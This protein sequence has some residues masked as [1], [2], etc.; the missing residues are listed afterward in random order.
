MC[1]RTVCG[2]ETNPQLP[3]VELSLSDIQNIFKPEFIRQLNRMFICGNYGDPIAAKD[4]LE[5]YKY[6]RQENP[7]IRLD[8]FTNGSAR[9]E[10]WW[11]ELAKVIDCIHF[12][13]DG[14]EDTNHLYRRGTHFPTIMKSI[15][16]Y[17]GN[18]G[19]AVWDFIVFRHNEHQIEEVKKLSEELGF[20]KLNIKKTGRFFSNTRMQVKDKQ[21]VFT[22]SG[23]VDYYIEMPLN[24]KYQNQALAKE[25]ALV[26]KYGSLE[27]YLDKT[28]IRC[29]VDEEK[30]MYLSAVG[31]AFPCCWTG[32]QLY[33]WYF[34]EKKSYMWK[35][36]NEL[37]NGIDDL[38]TKVHSLES[39]VN[40]PFFQKIMEN[41]W[42]RQSI[43]EGRPKCCAKTC[44][45][46]FDPFREQFI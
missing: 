30:S 41:S 33:P 23:E 43:K 11:Q 12:S 24:E 36:V 19:K 42:E 10:T 9:P 1:L 21:V 28:P 38:D 14:L 15:K 46:E 34:P 22:K 2:G 37:E 45:T 31:H 35:L 7:N 40:G 27:K 3:L 8:M 18:G 13:I 26:E 4:T 17:I 5:V 44:G 29:K 6:F 32:N 16:A 20:Q 25:M 39:V